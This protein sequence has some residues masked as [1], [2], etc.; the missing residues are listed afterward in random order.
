MN[1][2]K[3]LKISLLSLAVSLS[4]CSKQEEINA[5]NPATL[6]SS[7]RHIENS[8]QDNKQ[9]EQFEDG[10]RSIFNYAYAKNNGGAIY[11]DNKFEFS[12]MNNKLMSRPSEKEK[13]LADRTDQLILSTLNG[14]TLD[15]VITN[16]PKFDE[17]IR[18]MNAIYQKAVE[19]T[20]EKNDFLISEKQKI[21]EKLIK[22]QQDKNNHYL[23]EEASKVVLKELTQVNEELSKKDQEIDTLKAKLEPYE[24]ASIA[25]NQIQATNIQISEKK[26]DSWVISFDIAN[27]SNLPIESFDLNYA[28]SV[29]GRK[30]QI[31]RTSQTLETPIESE[32]SYNLILEKGRALLTNID[33]PS[34]VD[35]SL[36]FNK[37]T[38]TIDGQKYDIVAPTSEN[39]G[40][41]YLHS[42]LNRAI[43]EKSSL[44]KRLNFL[45]QQLK[46][47]QNMQVEDQKA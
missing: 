16:K 19:K 26:K 17:A 12:L 2:N 45:N 41:D 18:K 7:I 35:F 34:D 24:R 31:F 3:V 13:I 47:I 36:K 21:T 43:N 10:L 11:S 30:E 6:K 32:K 42:S 20:Q 46:E 14:M 22:E 28:L 29:K 33:S 27:H 1:I 44:N 39:Y 40:P 4:A 9:A 8:I 23:K 37:F 25:F 5:T 15:D 38:T